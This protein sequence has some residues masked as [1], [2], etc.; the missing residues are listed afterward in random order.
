M[1]H[2]FSG[3]LDDARRAIENGE[4]DIHENDMFLRTSTHNGR[5]DAVQFLLENGSYTY[6]ECMDCYLRAAKRG[7]L[8]VLQVFENYCGVKLETMNKALALAAIAGHFPVVQYLVPQ[9]A[10]IETKEIM[11]VQ[12]RGHRDIQNFMTYYRIWDGVCNN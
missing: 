5:F 3:R 10:D 6:E 2:I 7:H 9:G 12:K 1:N 8:E 11:E 4:I